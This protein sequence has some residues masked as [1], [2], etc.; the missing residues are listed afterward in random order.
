[1]TC[2]I[3]VVCFDKSS[4]SEFIDH[5]VD[6]FIVDKIDPFEFKKGIEWITCSYQK[7]N[8]NFSTL[9]EKLNNFDVKNISKQYIQLYKELMTNKK[10]MKK[11]Y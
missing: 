9:E 6:G 7:N 8:N 4:A 3:P 1:M 11:I 10:I 2:K 5:K